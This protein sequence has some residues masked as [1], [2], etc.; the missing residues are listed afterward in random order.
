MRRVVVTER[1]FH[2][3]RVY[4]SDGTLVCVFEHIDEE[5]RDMLLQKIT[6][7]VGTRVEIICTCTR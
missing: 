4:T 6:L 1:P 5:T 3:I 7:Q 2:D